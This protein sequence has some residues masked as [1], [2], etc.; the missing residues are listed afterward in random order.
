[1]V[2]PLAL[3]REVMAVSAHIPLLHEELFGRCG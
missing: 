3:G 2:L 1:M